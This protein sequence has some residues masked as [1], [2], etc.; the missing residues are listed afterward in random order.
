MSMLMLALVAGIAVGS[1]GTEPISTETEQRL[2]IGGYWEGVAYSV[3]S[4]GMKTRNARVEPGLVIEDNGIKW[5]CRWSDEGR[6]RCQL[7]VDGVRSLPCIYKR[8]AGQLIICYGYGN[9]RPTRFHAD[10][11]QILLILKPAKPPKK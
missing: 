7:I 5:F 1:D 3:D 10:K 8:E 4:G 6:G 11:T 2:A 9:R